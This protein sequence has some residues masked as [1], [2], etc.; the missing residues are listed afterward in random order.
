MPS[1]R[2]RKRSSWPS[3][4]A[5][6][7]PV[8]DAPVRLVARHD[9]RQ[10]HLPTRPITNRGTRLASR[11]PRCRVP[12]RYRGSLIVPDDAGRGGAPTTCTA[13][14]GCGLLLHYGD[15]CVQRDDGAGAAIVSRGRDQRHARGLSCEHCSRPALRPS[16]VHTASDPKAAIDNGER[17]EVSLVELCRQ[18]DAGSFGHRD[19]KGLGVSNHRAGGLMAERKA[20]GRYRSTVSSQ[21]I[22]QGVAPRDRVRGDRSWLDDR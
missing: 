15:A 19:G 7:G 6:G 4:C 3:D 5:R 13:L 18:R 11:S 12:R 20:R 9:V 16:D 1:S 22:N 14:Y 21:C 8:H 17:P 10:D 2:R